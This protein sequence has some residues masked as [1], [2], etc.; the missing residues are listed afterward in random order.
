MTIKVSDLRPG[1]IDAMN[2]TFDLCE[3][4]NANALTVTDLIQVC[5]VAID[6]GHDMALIDL[7]MMTAAIEKTAEIELAKETTE[8]E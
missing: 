6:K 7:C 5:R 1:C 3:A 2:A 8:D 4:I